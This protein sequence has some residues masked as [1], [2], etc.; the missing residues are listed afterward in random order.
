MA[1]GKCGSVGK[2]APSDQ[3]QALHRDPHQRSKLAL[4][5]V[6]QLAAHQTCAILLVGFPSECAARV[7]YILR[8]L[9]RMRSVKIFCERQV[10][11]YWN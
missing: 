7:R 3:R 4:F 6:S 5:P 8:K 9:S 10:F 1:M 11:S 2:I